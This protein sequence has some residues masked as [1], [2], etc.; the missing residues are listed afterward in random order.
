MD[1]IAETY[2]TYT[3]CVK[4][5]IKRYRATDKG[6]EKYNEGMRKYYD[7][8]KNDEEWVIKHRERCRLANQ[9]YRAKQKGIE[10]EELPKKKGRP[11]KI[12]NINSI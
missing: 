4:R 7:N 11:R 5:A 6:K 2:T 8:K 10:L 3:E 9:R 1:L 12:Q